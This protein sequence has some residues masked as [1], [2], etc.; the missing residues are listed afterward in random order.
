MENTRHERPAALAEMARQKYFAAFCHIITSRHSR[1]HAEHCLASLD[2]EWRLAARSAGRQAGMRSASRASRPTY[3][4]PA[5]SALSQKEQ[6]R[7]SR[8]SIEAAESFMPPG[9]TTAS[10]LCGS[11]SA[12]P[13]DETNRP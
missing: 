1:R 5:A 12:R 6:Y 2:W 10:V 9:A 8:Y 3:L 7:A 13:A 11:V 4:A